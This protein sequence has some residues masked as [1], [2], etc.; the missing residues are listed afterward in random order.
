MLRTTLGLVALGVVA[1][2]PPEVAETP[3]P[4][5]NDSTDPAMALTDAC[6]NRVEG[7]AVE[8]PAGWQVNTAGVLGPCALFDPDP[9]YL[10][11]DS[12]VSV[13]IAVSI[14]FEAGPLTDLTGDVLGRRVLS[15]TPASVDGRDALRIEAESTGEGLLDRGVRSYHYFVDLGDSTMVAGTYDTG[16]LPF[17]RKRRILDGMMGTFDFREPG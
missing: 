9:I 10:T 8:Y 15:R 6:V 7:Y 12:E 17:E 2:G 4:A 3:V 13:G 5:S 1:C 11:P 16:G 14:G